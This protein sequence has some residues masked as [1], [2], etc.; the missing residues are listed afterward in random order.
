MS[1]RKSQSTPL[2]R[3]GG[4]VTPRPIASCRLSSPT[5]LVRLM[6]IRLPVSRFSY[7]SI[8]SGSAFRKARTRPKKSS[9]GSNETP[10]I[11]KYEVI[12]RWPERSSNRRKICS[13]SRKQ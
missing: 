10:P 11:R 13:R 1:R 3:R 4:P 2:A 7:S 12:M 5:P 9:G 8:F 6:K